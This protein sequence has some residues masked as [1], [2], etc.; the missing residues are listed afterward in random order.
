MLHLGGR[1]RYL[2]GLLAVGLA[3][4]WTAQ[5]VLAQKQMVPPEPSAVTPEFTLTGKPSDY[6]QSVHEC[7]HCH[8][9]ETLEFEKT[10]HATI[11]FP[12]GAMSAFFSGATATPI[13]SCALCHGPDKAHTD[14]EEAAGDDQAKEAAA[15]K[16]VFNFHGSSDE[17]SRHCLSCH[18][19]SSDEENFAHSVHAAHGLSCTDCHAVHLVEAIEHPTEKNVLSAQEQFFSVPRQTVQ[20]S[21]LHDG[22]LLKPQPGLCYTCH[23]TI[24]ADFAMPVHHRVPEGLM[25]C[26]DC[27]NPH[28]TENPSMM[29]ATNWE[30]CVKCHVE[31]RGPFVYEHPVERVDGC[32]ACHDPHGSMNNFMLKRREGRE[33]CLQCHTGFHA[34]LGVPHGRLGFQT[35]GECV[36][37]HVQVHGSNFDPNFLF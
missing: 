32:V 8:R 23:A 7:E 27:H 19:S 24:G 9:A 25:K 21:W 18:T 5:V 29:T 13:D 33:L 10:P 36:R 28:G 22:Q 6:V 20:E 37:C 3:I 4:A 1:F 11:K 12:K 30:T 2:K 34:Q 14:A 31:K 17:N 35:S 26:S 15:G 16:L